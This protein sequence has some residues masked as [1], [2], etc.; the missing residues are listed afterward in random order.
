MGIM[1]IA[2]KK[3]FILYPH[4]V[5]RDEMI[6][7]LIMNGYESYVL[8]DHKRALRLLEHFPDSIMFINID[9]GLKEKEW[10]AYIKG[11]Q[12]NEKTKT[13]RLGILSYN[14]DRQ[15][16]EKYLMKIAVPCG[17]IQLKLGVPASTKIMLDALQANEARGRRKFIR[18]D[19][20]DDAGA[21]LNY[22][23]EGGI[24][25]GKILDISSAGIA[26]RIEKFGYPSN[27]KLKAIQLKLRGSLVMVNAVLIGSRQGDENIHILLFEPGMSNDNK[28][29]IHRFIKY[30]LQ[31]FIDNLK[32]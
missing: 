11:I 28:L 23:D 26:A 5:I 10:E 22:K 31:R 13:I 14:N 2:G 6:D 7:V 17:Y 29:I 8:H 24:H 4:S 19:C 30:C 1:D 16:M 27:A 18:A 3:I 25:Y 21:T 20:A 9:E 32:I 12:E 15:L